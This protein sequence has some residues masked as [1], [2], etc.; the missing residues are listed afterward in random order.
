[1]RNKSDVYICLLSV[2]TI[3]FYIFSKNLPI[4][5]VFLRKENNGNFQQRNSL[6]PDNF[7]INFK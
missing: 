2:S 1:M 3:A 4:H 5:C 7:M 6:N